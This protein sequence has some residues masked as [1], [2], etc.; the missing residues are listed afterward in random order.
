MHPPA[1][2]CQQCGKPLNAQARF[3]GRCGSPIPPPGPSQAEAPA[4]PVLAQPIAPPTAGYQAPAAETILGV[5][6]GAAYSTGLLGMRKQNFTIIITA[7]RLIFAC[8][9]NEMMRAN[10]QRSRE[11]ARQQGT[12]FFGRWGAQLGANSG[13]HYLGIP[14]RQILAEHPE[15][16]F[17]YNNQVNTAR[18][19]QNNVN[20][21]EVTTYAIE[22]KAASGKYQF[23]FQSL[24]V[25]RTRQI[26]KQ[27]LGKALR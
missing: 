19:K 24:D 14:A 15:N 7:H 8:Q 13:E 18:V 6:P 25:R 9:T 26:L 27:A 17:L 22:L 10:V 16:W 21:D 20:D 1:Q 2:F 23:N 12:G 3:C 4:P 11:E 5:I